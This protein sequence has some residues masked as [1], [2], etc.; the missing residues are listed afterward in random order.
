MSVRNVCNKTKTTKMCFKNIY[1]NM[2]EYKTYTKYKLTLER[3]NAELNNSFQMSGM[4]KTILDKVRREKPFQCLIVFIFVL[5]FY[6]L[7]NHLMP[8]V[9]LILKARGKNG[10]DKASNF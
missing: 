7:S 6:L 1:P 8:E 10:Q 4:M 9:P 5:I 2:A 3:E